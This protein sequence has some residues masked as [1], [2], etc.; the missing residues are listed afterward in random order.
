MKKL[1]ITAVM[2]CMVSTA[3][4]KIR[5]V[6]AYPYIAD[7]TKRIGG[8]AVEVHALAPGDW[9]PHTV[10][11]RP[12]YIAKLRNADLLIIN[13][14]ELEIGWM[15][16]LIRE[17]RN[18]R[19]QVGASGF[20]DLSAFVRLI[21]KPDAVSRALG[22][23]HPSGNPH[24]VLGPD[25]IPKIANGIYQKLCKLDEPD[26]AAFKRNL[27]NFE[28][29]WARRLTGWKAEM[30]RMRGVKIIEYHKLFD[31][32]CN[33]FGLQIVMELEPLPGIPPTSASIEKVIKTVKRESIP[34]IVTDVY[35]PVD[36]ARFVAEKTGARLVILPQDV[37]A[38]KGDDDIF[39]LYDT[40]IRRLTND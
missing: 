32:F 2:M 25:N 16:P 39:S 26:C 19:V 30:S 38:V 1:I 12:S 11:P 9:D 29:E 23:V 18:Y 24:Y 31:Y 35:H 28:E 6:A 20:L 34:I 22:D 13:G 36:A 37:H 21:E 15:P 33:Y 40:I 3:Y 14:G 7:L 17:S 4:A 10:V 8:E 5:V 27:N